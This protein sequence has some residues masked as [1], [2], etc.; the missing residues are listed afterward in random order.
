MHNFLVEREYC[1]AKVW[2]IVGQKIGR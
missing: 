1:D 2:A